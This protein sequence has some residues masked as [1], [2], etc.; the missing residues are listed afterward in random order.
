MSPRRRPYSH[1]RRPKVN[2]VTTG[3]LLTGVLLGLLAGQHPAAALRAAQIRCLAASPL[4]RALAGD[5]HGFSAGAW[6]VA[7]RQMPPPE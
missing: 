6:R 7:T 2:D 4:G 5:Q 3:Y 1:R